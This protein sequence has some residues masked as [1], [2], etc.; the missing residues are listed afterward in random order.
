MKIGAATLDVIRPYDSVTVVDADQLQDL[1]GLLSLNQ[2]RHE[3]QSV[4]A[5]TS[6]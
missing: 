5:D 6:I 2:S 1:T 3:N 4:Q